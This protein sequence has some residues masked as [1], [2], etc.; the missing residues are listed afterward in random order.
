[1]EKYENFT[2]LFNRLGDR[3]TY[4]GLAVKEI[5]LTTTTADRARDCLIYLSA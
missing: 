5:L 4:D 2:K 1:M 3:L